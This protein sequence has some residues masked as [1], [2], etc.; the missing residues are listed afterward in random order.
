MA[1]TTSMAAA[2]A[3]LAAL[4]TPKPSGALYPCN[5]FGQG[6]TAAVHV[7]AKLVLGGHT[8]AGAPAVTLTPGTAAQSMRPVGGGVAADEKRLRLQRVAAWSAAQQQPLPT[9]ALGCSA[10]SSWLALVGDAT[11]AGEHS[12]SGRLYGSSSGCRGGRRDHPGIASSS[13]S[14]SAGYGSDVTPAQPQQELQRTPAARAALFTGTYAM[15]V[16]F[17]LVVA[18]LRVF[19]TCPRN[20]QNSSCRLLRLRCFCALVC[21][22]CRPL[23][24]IF[25]QCNELSPLSSL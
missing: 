22:H 17:A 21:M 10:P 25:V 13:S 2:A 23:Q 1:A 15:T 9:N 16:G 14:G 8:P 12:A 18:P 24:L 11:P 20:C 7:A 6:S 5:I 19:G 3:P 4:H